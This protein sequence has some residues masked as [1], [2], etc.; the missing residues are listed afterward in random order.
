VDRCDQR[1]EHDEKG[2]VQIK[3]HHGQ[4]HIYCPKSTITID[5]R[6]EPCPEDVFVL[7]IT[8]TFK[9]NDELFEGSQVHLDHLETMDPLFTMR[10]NWH[11]QPK[12]NL[13]YLLQSPLVPGKTI[14]TEMTPYMHHPM[15]W[16]TVGALA[17]IVILV[18][19]IV[20]LYYY[21]RKGIKVSV[22]T[23]PAEEETVAQD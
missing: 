17:V 2:F 22:V 9:V 19:V 6:T 13:S 16:T 5:G 8:A 12:V 15:T 21:S 7:P 4:N 20:V 3:P 14:H 23:K 11:L 18:T 10:A 1:K